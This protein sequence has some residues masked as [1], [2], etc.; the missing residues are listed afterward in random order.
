M[1]GVTVF[2]T[3][4][5]WNT[6]KQCWRITQAMRC[7][8]KYPYFTPQKGWEFPGSGEICNP[9]KLR[10]VCNL[11]GIGFGTGR[12]GYFLDL[13]N[14]SHFF[15][16]LHMSR[17]ECQWGRTKDCSHLHSIRL[18]WS[19]APEL[20]VMF[21]K[22]WVVFLE[23]DDCTI[24]WVRVMSL[25]SYEV[26]GDNVLPIQSSNETKQILYQCHNNYYM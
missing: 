20:G 5:P 23:S 16:V 13:S 10:K 15:K 6:T 26:N 14:K 24:P 22:Y 7:F 1:Q 21:L 8:T 3:L 12:C 2:H 9:K 11:I 4:D 25:K 17:I 19:T 18:M